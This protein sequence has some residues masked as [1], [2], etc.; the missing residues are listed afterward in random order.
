ML[1]HLIPRFGPF[2]ALSFKD[3]T[4][5][6]ED[7][8][9]KS[10]DNVVTQFHRLVRQVEDGDFKIPNRNLDTG[11][12]T[13]AGQYRLADQAYGDLVR[14]LAKEHFA[15]L[16]PDLK[17]SMLAYFASGSAGEHWKTRKWKET[18][19]DLAKLKEVEVRVP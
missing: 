7:M 17:T 5:Q 4:P 12:L 14:R 6:T 10:M 16:T 2:K 18:E 15:H 19:K 9:F 11:E 1:G 13:R 3:P 8:Y